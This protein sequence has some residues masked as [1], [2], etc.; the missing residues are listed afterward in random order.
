V[1]VSKR[2]RYVPKGIVIQRQIR[3]NRHLA[4]NNQTC[5]RTYPEEGEE[6]TIR[7]NSAKLEKEIG[8]ENREKSGGRQERETLGKRKG[9]RPKEGGGCRSTEEN[10][11]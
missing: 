10:P 11:E 9:K 2:P 7:S 5:P 8:R 1:P 6:G 4:P 3:D